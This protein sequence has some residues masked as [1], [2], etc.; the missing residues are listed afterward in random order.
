MNE[1]TDVYVGL[2]G[3]PDQ[4][5]NQRPVPLGPIRVKNWSEILD[6]FGMRGKREPF[7]DFQWA[8]WKQEK[9]RWTRSRQLEQRNQT[10]P[11]PGEGGILVFELSIETRRMANSILEHHVQTTGENHVLLLDDL[12][13]LRTLSCLLAFPPTCPIR[14]LGRCMERKASLDEYVATDPYTFEPLFSPV[15]VEQR[16]VDIRTTIHKASNRPT[17]TLEKSADGVVY[18]LEMNGFIQPSRMVLA[19]PV[20]REVLELSANNGME[21]EFHSDEFS[22]PFILVGFQKYLQPALREWVMTEVTTRK[23]RELRGIIDDK[24]RSR[25]I[26]AEVVS[27]LIA[28]PANDPN[29][30]D[31]VKFDYCHAFMKELS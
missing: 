24:A 27:V 13:A 31:E 28:S 19:T 30:R 9:D 2:L 25:K 22:D 15:I 16:Y 20:T 7:D 29:V 6:F 18:A 21:V 5:E 4:D 11:D 3:F 12:R 1:G 14:D 8:I 17:P 26:L 10:I 23:F